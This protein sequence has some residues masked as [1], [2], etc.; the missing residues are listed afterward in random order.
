MNYLDSI[1]R[2][3]R[4]QVPDCSTEL[5]RYYALLTLVKG[6][7]VTLE[8]VHNAWSAWRTSTRPE[9]PSIVPFAELS[10][11]VQ[12]LDRPYMEAIREVALAMND[13]F[14]DEPTYMGRPLSVEDRIYYEKTVNP[15]QWLMEKT[16]PIVD[17][18]LARSQ[19]KI[20]HDPY[21]GGD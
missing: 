16:Q 20:Q 8:D 18:E 1:A 4:H 19:E 14:K 13:E 12:E 9:H 7:D 2:Q 3:I 5:L 6:E 17:E 15:E 11:E 21:K 10:S